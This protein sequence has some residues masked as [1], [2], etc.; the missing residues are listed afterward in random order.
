MFHDWENFIVSFCFRV[1]SLL[2]FLLFSFF[3][4]T[5]CFFSLFWKEK[6]LWF[7]FLLF[8]MT[9]VINSRRKFRFS[10]F[11]RVWF[12]ISSFSYLNEKRVYLPS[13]EP[14][15]INFGWPHELNNHS[16]W[17]MATAGSYLGNNIGSFVSAATIAVI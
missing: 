14:P 9:T 1:S 4:F 16:F 6:K 17:E 2:F 11:V 12:L 13:L 15:E 8:I 10:R 3:F 7:F 5:S